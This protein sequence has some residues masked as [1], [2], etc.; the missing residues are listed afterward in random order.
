M[1]SIYESPN[2]QVMALV[3]LRRKYYVVQLVGKISGQS[4]RACLLQVLKHSKES[5]ITK[6]ILNTKDLTSNPDLAGIWLASHF[7]RRFYKIHGNLRLAV[8]NPK[9]KISQFTS[10][11]LQVILKPMRLEFPLRFFQSLKE[12]QSWIMAEGTRQVIEEIPGVKNGLKKLGMTEKG[13][14]TRFKQFKLNKKHRLNLRVRFS[15][16]G[17]LQ[18]SRLPL[19]LPSV[20]QIKDKIEQIKL[21]GGLNKLTRRES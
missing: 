10:A 17:D 16:N 5:S 11:W 15:A 19:E 1:K 9:R 18:P 13:E 20:K 4:Y 21:K 7:I 14:I 8:V 3:D 6:I 12:S 2:Q